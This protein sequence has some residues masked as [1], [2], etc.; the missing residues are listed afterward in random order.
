MPK[1]NQPI[2]AHGAEMSELEFRNPNGGD[3]AACGFPFSFTVTEEGA[4]VIH[5]NAPAIT[6]LISRL[7]NIPLSSARALSFADWMA[8]MTEIFS[9]FGQSMPTSSNG[10][11]TLRGSGNGTRGSPSI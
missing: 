3:V 8:C 9:F 5:P 6:A 10:A 2:Q 11:S 1:L 4:Q 7:G